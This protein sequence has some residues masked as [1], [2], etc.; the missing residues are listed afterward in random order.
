ML[1]LQILPKPSTELIVL[2]VWSLIMTPEDVLATIA[3][4]KTTFVPIIRKTTDDNLL[5]IKECLTPALLGIIYN[6]SDGSHNILGVL[7][8]NLE[9][10]ARHNS[11]FVPPTRPDIYPTIPENAT[12]AFSSLSKTLYK[13][14]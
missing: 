6:T 3:S 11:T 7:S 1:N 10:S 14:L 12:S 2:A 4:A 8:S 13:L 5:R 9:Y